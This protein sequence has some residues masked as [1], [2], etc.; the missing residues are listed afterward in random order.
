MCV[1][2][3]FFSSLPISLFFPF[4]L[5]SLFSSFFF[6][7]LLLF[8]CNCK[9]YLFW[10][11]Y[12]C[13]LCYNMKRWRTINRHSFNGPTDKVWIPPRPKWYFFVCFFMT[14]IGSNFFLVVQGVFGVCHPYT[15]ANLLK[16]NWLTCRWEI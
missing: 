8:F 1:L 10:K 11:Y 4:S 2:R 16:Q 9:H 13:I 7:F 14:K 6:L 3:Q 15:K 5:V 12:S